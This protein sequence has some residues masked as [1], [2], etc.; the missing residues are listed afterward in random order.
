MKAFVRFFLR[1]ELSWSLR[2]W[3]DGVSCVSGL[4]GTGVIGSHVYPALRDW[5]DGVSCVSESHRHWRDTASYLA[6]KTQRLS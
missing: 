1:S 3:C 2:D 5:R 4:C 6:Q